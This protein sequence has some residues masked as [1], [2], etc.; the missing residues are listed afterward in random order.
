[1]EHENAISFR[2]ATVFGFSPRMRIDLLVNYFVNKALTEGKIQ[3]FEGHF[4][5]NYVHIKDVVNV[6]LFT[7]NN[8][9]KM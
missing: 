7:I 2:L 1:M 9:E 5:R 3:I 6:F 4:K 8:F